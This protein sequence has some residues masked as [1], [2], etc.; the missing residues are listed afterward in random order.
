MKI[1]LNYRAWLPAALALASCWAP[2]ARA[3]DQIV[4]YRSQFERDRDQWLYEN[5]EVISWGFGLLAA[6]FGGW[7]AVNVLWPMVRRRR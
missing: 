4:V 1:T 7:I 3:A 5:P 6:V 2:A